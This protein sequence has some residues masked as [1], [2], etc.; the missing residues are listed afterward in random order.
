M[1]KTKYGVYTN[2]SK[3]IF[4][5][6]VLNKNGKDTPELIFSGNEQ[7][8]VEFTGGTFAD[9]EETAKSQPEDNSAGET[10]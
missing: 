3:T 9:V 1:S 8:C 5:V 2:P 6:S 10:E 7:Q 4:A